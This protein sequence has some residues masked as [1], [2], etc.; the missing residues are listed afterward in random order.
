MVTINIKLL[1]KFFSI[2][3]LLSVIAGKDYLHE[4]T[5]YNKTAS[6]QFSNNPFPRCQL[7]Y[8]NVIKVFNPTGIK[9]KN[10]WV[11]DLDKDKNV[12]F[13]VQFSDDRDKSRTT[14]SIH[15][16]DHLN[17]KIKK[18]VLPGLPTAYTLNYRGSDDYKISRGMILRSYPAY[19]HSDSDFYP[20]LGTYNI[21][22]VVN[23]FNIKIKKIEREL[24]GA[25][26]VFYNDND[27]FNS[28][29]ENH[30]TKGSFNPGDLIALKQQQI[31]DKKKQTELLSKKKRISTQVKQNIGFGSYILG[32]KLDNSVQGKRKIVAT[33]KGEKCKADIVLSSTKISKQIMKIDVIIHKGGKPNGCNLTTEDILDAYMQKYGNDY[34][35]YNI[36]PV[37]IERYDGTIQAT[38]CVEFEWML[39]NDTRGVSLTINSLPNKPYIKFNEYENKIEDK[40]NEIEIIYLDIDLWE[41]NKEEEKLLIQKKKNES[42]GEI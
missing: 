23:G 30:T 24:N 40:F 18:L 26:L 13:F 12:E 25:K 41:L 6:I 39:S 8:N 29:T 16:Y 21:Y 22:Y 32:Q 37:Q 5:I 33:I 35:T 34:K 31:L 36:S 28:S 17:V 1:F 2:C 42:P 20:T 11:T 19:S 38:K 3:I 27:P 9:I 15:V 7:T 14:L 10:S 4:F